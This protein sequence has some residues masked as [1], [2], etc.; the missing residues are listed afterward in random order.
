MEQRSP[1]SP[2]FVAALI[3]FEDRLC[4]AQGVESAG[5]NGRDGLKKERT[6]GSAAAGAGGWLLNR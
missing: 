2:Q 5:P 4:A 3:E 1:Y 6:A